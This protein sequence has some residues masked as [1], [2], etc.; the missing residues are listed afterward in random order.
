[1][2]MKK[3]IQLPS[4]IE[5]QDCYIRVDSVTI[6][7]KENCSITVNFYFDKTKVPVKQLSLGCK[8]EISGA[9]PIAQAYEHLKT[10]PEFTGA[11]DC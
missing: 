8:Y 4:G 1:M 6:S 11:T 5:V 10:L 2:A 3:S 9:N 7:Q